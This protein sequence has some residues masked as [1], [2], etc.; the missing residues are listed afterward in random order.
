MDMLYEYD[1]W[2]S[3]LSTANEY[4]GDPYISIAAKLFNVSIESVT[5]A[6]RK[7]AKVAAFTSRSTSLRS[8]S[9]THI[10]VDFGA[11]V[12]E[13]VELKYSPNE[14]LYSLG[15]ENRLP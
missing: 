9:K 4:R 12:S 2:E 7:A 15:A 5:P 13:T 8:L 11:G 1:N 3:G 14:P 10:G 6:Q